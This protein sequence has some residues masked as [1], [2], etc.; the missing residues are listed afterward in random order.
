VFR[1]RPAP[2]T[3]VPIRLCGSFS[4]ADGGSC[5][6]FWVVPGVKMGEARGMYTMPAS[7][8]SWEIEA[9]SRRACRSAC[10]FPDLSAA[11]S[12]NR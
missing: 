5:V 4:P 10:R 12:K 11:S 1:A 9:W 7:S 2:F 3:R 6:S 8:A